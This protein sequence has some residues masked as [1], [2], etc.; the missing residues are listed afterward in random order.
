M[1]HEPGREATLNGGEIR[2]ALVAPTPF[3]TE[4]GASSR[5]LGEAR[6]LRS[7][8]AT[9]RILTYPPG[10][11]WPGLEILRPRASQR[12]MGIGFHPARILYDFELLKFLLALPMRSGEHLHVFLHEGAALGLLKG[13]LTQ[14]SF[15]LDLQGSLVEEVGRTFRFAREG[16]LGGLARR[17]E[18][19]LERSAS[20]V[21]VSSPGLLS[22]ISA[23]DR[24]PP[25]RLHFIPDGVA[26]EDFTPSERQD[27]ELRSKWRLQFG[28]TD[29]DV[30]AIYVGGLSPEQGI[31]D[32]IRHAPKMIHE[33]P[34][35][36][37]LLFGVPTQLHR[38]EDYVAQIRRAG[39]GKRLQMPGPLHYEDLP[40]ALGSSEIAL[41]WKH[42]PP[43]EANG[44]IPHYMAAGLPSVAL[45]L[46][47][48]EYY[49]GHNGEFGGV[50][51]Q[52]VA[53][54]VD[55]VVSLAGDRSQRLRLGRLARKYAE[56]RLSLKVAASEI[57]RIYRELD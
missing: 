41:T 53:E 8:G 25:D 27:P 4:G 50:L 28:L 22:A 51:S 5:I 54:A 16:W 11:N 15:L 33:C 37:F 47:A 42:S 23:R 39:L 38:F 17:I 30:V 49:L 35:L 57:L 43:E 3:F 48:S 19:A 32:L 45:R 1:K 9:V 29:D 2:T 13:R 10:R 55:A 31:N 52:T 36:C 14:R 6:G 7:L 26:T 44:K 20:H 34:K 24:I 56:D 12:R 21:I 40:L 18:I 46:P